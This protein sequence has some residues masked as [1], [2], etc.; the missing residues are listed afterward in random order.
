MSS[1]DPSSPVGHAAE[2]LAV[3]GWCSSRRLDR[4]SGRLFPEDMQVL[5]AELAPVRLTSD[6]HSLDV[7]REE[8]KTRSQQ[9]NQNASEIAPMAVH[10]DTSWQ[11]Y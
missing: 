2:E 5:V 9:D 1:C 3:V 7:A 4:G 10:N 11:E 8:K 6:K